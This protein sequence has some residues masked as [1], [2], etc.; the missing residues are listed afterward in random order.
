MPSLQGAQHLSRPNAKRICSAKSWD[1][2]LG[3]LPDKNGGFSRNIEPIAARIAFRLAGKV[4]NHF[5]AAALWPSQ[6]VGEINGERFEV[7]HHAGESPICK[8][9][10]AGLRGGRKTAEHNVDARSLVLPM[11]RRRKAAGEAHPMRPM[12]RRHD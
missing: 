8:S 1:A 4:R 2:P 5:R 6:P 7:G 12:L 3:M 9:D 10:R 11:P